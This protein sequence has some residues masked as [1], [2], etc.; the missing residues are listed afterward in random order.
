MGIDSYGADSIKAERIRQ[1]TEEGWTAEHDDAHNAGQLA[2]A[3]ACYAVNGLKQ[4]KVVKINVSAY[5]G[6]DDAWPW[7]AKWDKRRTHSRERQLVIAGALIA[8]EIDRLNRQELNAAARQR[9]ATM[10]E[11]QSM[12]NNP[13]DNHVP[14]KALDLAKEISRARF[15]DRF[16]EV[17]PCLEPLADRIRAVQKAY[18]SN[19]RE[20]ARKILASAILRAETE[21]ISAASNGDAIADVIGPMDLISA[22]DESS[23][24]KIGHS[25]MGQNTIDWILCEF[26]HHF[27]HAGCV[28]DKLVGHQDKWRITI[29]GLVSP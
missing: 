24:G 16:S 28:A 29:P 27:E 8:A 2:I 21:V 26:K 6:F 11:E 5:L 20:V 19:A 9:I 25:A 15:G 1:A 3:A 23:E 13:P 12:A 7:H 17:E 4:A 18:V 22:R 10:L 14:Q